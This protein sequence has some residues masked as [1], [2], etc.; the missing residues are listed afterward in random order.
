MA[1]SVPR[2]ALPPRI[3]AKLPPSSPLAPF[4]CDG[5]RS[6]TRA[7]GLE[8]PHPPGGEGPLAAPTDAPM[9]IRSPD[10][11]PELDSELE[12]ALDLTDLAVP[13]PPGLAFSGSRSGSQPAP[14]P[15][16]GSGGDQDN[17]VACAAAGGLVAGAGAT[18]GFPAAADNEGPAGGKERGGTHGG[19]GPEAEAMEGQQG[20]QD[21]EVEA[22]Q[23]APD[24]SLKEEVVVWVVV[25]GPAAP[26]L[27]HEEW[28]CLGSQTLTQL[29]DAHG[30]YLYLEGRFFSDTRRAGAEDY[31]TP[32]VELCRAHGVRPS[33]VQPER[34]TRLYDMT[35]R[36]ANVPTGIFCHRACCEH[37][38][39]IRDVRRRCFEALHIDPHDG[40]RLAP[41]VEGVCWAWDGLG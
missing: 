7:V 12:A 30:S 31:A 3:P 33:F 29:R 36:A 32:I 16:P 26:N 28:M 23:E 40:S 39:F 20:Q 38:V 19:P 35:L 41:Q 37:L 2:P 10:P 21:V 1:R 6:T 11:D 17:A 25:C 4:T 9:P 22:A 15:Q 27:P 14:Q 18:G 5:C 8:R 34:H 24:P 13:L